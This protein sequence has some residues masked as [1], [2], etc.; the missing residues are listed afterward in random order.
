[1]S[2]VFTPEKRSDVM[3][4]IR[5]KGNMNTELAMIKIFKKHKIKGW[6]RNGKVF[7]KPD[8]VFP[9]MKIAVFVDGCF[10]H[11]CSK[12]YN[13]PK[14]N[15]EFWEKKIGSNVKRD[16]VVNKTLKDKGW[17][18]IRIWEHEVESDE[19]AVLRKLAQLL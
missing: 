9:K 15:K 1:M 8:F 14:Q 4:K 18:V 3:S 5:S 2:D 12:H 7:G 19:E 10:W 6:R 17:L 13:K 16:K 11:R